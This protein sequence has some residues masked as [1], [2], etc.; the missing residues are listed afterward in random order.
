M[1][2]LITIIALIAFSFSSI[3]QTTPQKC[4]WSKQGIYYSNKCNEYTFELGWKDTCVSYFTIRKNMKTFKIDTLSDDRIFKTTFK[5][6]GYYTI[7]STFKNR[8]T[9]C[10]TSMYLKLKVECSKTAN[11]NNVEVEK[12]LIYPNPFD[13]NII[14]FEWKGAVTDVLI[15]NYLGKIVFKGN[16]WNK[17]INVEL[18]PEGYYI[19]QIGKSINRIYISH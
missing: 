16:T 11:T 3:A 10:D 14:E 4:D 2:K 5:D 7:K 1:K 17:S 9:K 12:V 6:T 19:I 8:C 18:W 15:Y 13:S